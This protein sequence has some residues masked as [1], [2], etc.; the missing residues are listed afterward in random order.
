MD[1]LTRKCKKCNEEKILETSFIK[2]N[3]N[4][5]RWTC[6][7]CFNSN[8]NKW[9]HIN[10]EVCNNYH[11]KWRNNSRGYFNEYLKEYKKDNYDPIKKHI[12]Y[13]KYYYV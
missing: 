13:I 9:R 2:Y 7:E 5:Y 6:R 3:K 12:Q 10:K 11:T 8:I 4:L 1:I